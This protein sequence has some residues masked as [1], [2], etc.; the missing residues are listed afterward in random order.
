MDD[1]VFVESR[2]MGQDET[3]S[4]STELHS[5]QSR[6]RTSLTPRQF[7]KEAFGQLPSLDFIA[8]LCSSRD[9]VKLGRDGEAKISIEVPAE[10]MA[11]A[12]PIITYKNACFRVRIEPLAR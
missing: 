8:Y 9:P 10:E 1:A 5:R 2:E 7:A 3:R 6:R 4:D 11:K 12:L